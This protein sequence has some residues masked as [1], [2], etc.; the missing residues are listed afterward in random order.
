MELPYT[1][2]SL[3]WSEFFLAQLEEAELSLAPLRVSGVH[4]GRVD[5]LSARGPVSLP[6]NSG[7]GAGDLAVGDWVLADEARI[8]RCL[9][10]K[11]DLSR[12]AAGTGHAIQ[13]IAANIDTLF[14][15]TSCNADFNPA[16]LERYLAI[17]VEAGTE[18]VILLTKADTSAEAE[19]YRKRAEALQRALVVLA[20]DARDPGVAETLGPWCLAGQTVAL[21]G[22]S[23]VGK[24]TLT[25]TLTGKDAATGPIREDDA[26]GRHTTTVRSLHQISGG[27]WLVDTP[28][29]RSLSVA[30]AGS[31]VDAVFRDVTELLG[32]CRFR[33]CSHQTEPGCSIRRAVDEGRLDPDR[34]ARWQ[35]LKREERVLTETPAEARNR[36]RRF[37]G[38]VK[39]SPAVKAR[40]DGKG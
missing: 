30:D 33:D 9:E 15:V 31:G 8:L 10:R 25:N 29:M 26:R 28:G 1:L 35:K 19:T 39:K 20:L 17:A 2:A 21:V 22:S 16:R 40:R 11:T 34:L 23:G 24:T 12:P 13:R 7:L 37:G 14:V 32:Q 3:G 4:R 38:V 27:G 6:L 18:A 36:A 5:A